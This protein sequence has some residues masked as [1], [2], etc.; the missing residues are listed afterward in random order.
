M[1]ELIQ[2]YLIIGFLLASVSWTVGQDIPYS[3]P[4][5]VGMSAQ[6]LAQIDK[7]L[8]EYVERREVPGFV[9][10]IARS[11]KIVHWEAHGRIGIDIVKPMSKNAIFDVASMTKPITAISVMILY[12]EGVLLLSDPISKF[13][14][15][16]KSPLVQVNDNE[17]IPVNREV[18][19]YDLL[20]HTSGGIKGDFSRIEKFTYPTLSDYMNDLAQTALQFQPGDQWL[21]DDSYD[22]LGYLVEVISGQRLDEFWQ[23][24]IF[25]PLGMLDTHYWLPSDKEVRRPILLYNGRSDPQRINRYPTL[26]AERKSTILGAGGLHTTVFD[27]WRFCQMLLNGGE[28]DGVRLLSN[29]TIDWMTINHIGDLEM[30]NWV[31][32]GSRYGFGFGIIA[33]PGKSTQPIST[34]AYYWGGAL[35]TRFLIDSEEELI[36]IIMAQVRPYNQLGYIQ[37][38]QAVVYSSLVD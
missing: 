2:V 26:A 38:F 14:P 13:L 31:P 6:R 32:Q 37:K 3:E 27:Y 7:V 22:V 29:K 30:A 15:E 4:D 17:L 1:R 16:F 24:R 9:T 5:E 28:L 25:G 20:T 10:L 18:T 23:E 12:E 19:V 8:S 21:Y 33:D 36:C 34:G 11:G 35:G